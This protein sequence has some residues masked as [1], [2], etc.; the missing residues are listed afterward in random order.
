MRL[1]VDVCFARAKARG[2]GSRE[3]YYSDTEHLNTIEP[4]RFS[5]RGL[6]DSYVFNQ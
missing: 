1:W 2:S 5:A 6:R 4:F 3:T